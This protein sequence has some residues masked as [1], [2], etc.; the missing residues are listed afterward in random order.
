L[1]EVNEKYHNNL[2]FVYAKKGSYDQALKEFMAGRDEAG[3]HYKMAQ[4]LSQMHD[5]DRAETHFFIS[6]KLSSKL[7]QAKTGSHEASPLAESGKRYESKPANGQLR[8][9][10]N[11]VE[12]DKKGK[13]KL[14]FKINTVSLQTAE[15]D[16]FETGISKLNDRLELTDQKNEKEKQSSSSEF[17][18]EVSNGNGVNR[19]A[20]RIGNYLKKKGV[21]VTRLTNAEHFNFEE[22]IIYYHWAHLKDA[23][24]VAQEIPGY[25]NMEKLGASDQ[26][27]EKIKVRIGKDLVLYDQFFVEHTKDHNNTKISKRL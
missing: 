13:K 5:Y 14:W 6:S 18:V 21:K 8:G 25:Q 10:P 9:I 23:F 17:T 12:V 20:T 3:A 4:V 15:D 1:D 26:K 7:H 19:M 16:N 2:G 24:K 11:R 22:T 27:S